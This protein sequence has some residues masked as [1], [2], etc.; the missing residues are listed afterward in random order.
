MRC[1]RVG[2]VGRALLVLLILVVLLVLLILL[3]VAATAV[4]VVAVV[5][6]ATS[7]AAIEWSTSE[8]TARVLGATLDCANIGRVEHGGCKLDAPEQHRLVQMLRLGN[9]VVDTRRKI[10]KSL[11][12]SC[13]KKGFG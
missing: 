9:R 1:E 4:V 7:S 3:V 12:N 2:W 8:R 11:I 13:G 10:S 5:H 6:T